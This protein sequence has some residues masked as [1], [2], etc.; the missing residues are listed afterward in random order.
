MRQNGVSLIL[1]FVLI[2]IAAYLAYCDSYSYNPPQMQVKEQFNTGYHG[3]Q[4]SNYY[5]FNTAYI[6][7]NLSYQK[8][9]ALAEFGYPSQYQSMRYYP[10]LNLPPAVIGCGGRKQPCLGGSQVVIPNEMPPIDISNNNIAPNTLYV[11]GYDEGT[12]QV[13]VLTKVFGKDNNVWPLYGR[14]M[15]RND[16][17]WEYFTRMGQFG[18]IMP[19]IP[20]RNNEELNTND[21]V[22]IDGMEEKYRVTVYDND[23][24]QYL[25]V[26]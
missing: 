16:N 2:A 12:Q 23:I 20:Y 26:Y 9:R 22:A 25:P 11:R 10:N 7:E 13:G 14:K 6:P 24:P 21:E 17:K 5:P 1:I 3:A 15:Y 19:V 18:V 8:Q 4:N